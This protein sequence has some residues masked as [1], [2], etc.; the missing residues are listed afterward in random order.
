ML[1]LCPGLGTIEEVTWAK[2][3]LMLPYVNVHVIGEQEKFFSIYCDP[4]YV[5]VLNNNELTKDKSPRYSFLEYEHATRSHQLG[6]C[7]G[8]V[9]GIALY[10]IE[11]DDGSEETVLNFF[12]LRLTL[13][14]VDRDRGVLPLPLYRCEKDA[15]DK[16]QFQID[17]IQH[18]HIKKPLF[19]ITAVDQPLRC[20]NVNKIDV[21]SSR[22]YVLGEDVTKCTHRVPYDV[23]VDSLSYLSS[24]SNKRNN[25]QFNLYSQNVYMSFNELKKAKEVF[26]VKEKMSKKHITKKNK[27]EDSNS[28]TEEE[29]CVGVDSQKV[30]NNIRT[31]KVGGNTLHSNSSRRTSN[32]SSSRSSRTAG[33][34]RNKVASSDDEN[35][36][37]L[38]T[39][40]E[41]E[42]SNEL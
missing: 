1:R 36:S 9:V 5:S 4:N 13:T 2:H 42:N 41:D 6:P 10:S 27:S 34:K 33:K 31:S 16:Q 26:G 14:D 21:T 37:Y 29:F 8:I 3:M 32:S 20:M 17:P 30:D 19:G 38:S 35:V 25:Q 39:L 28:D 23:Y 40:L 24:H 7:I 18:V 12:M 15:T 11:K 22:F